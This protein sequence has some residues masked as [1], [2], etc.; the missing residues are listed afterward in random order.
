MFFSIVITTYN[1]EPYILDAL[2]S[3]K[4]QTFQD[5]E[6]IITD[7]FSTDNTL[8]VCKA[9]VAKHP[10]FQSRLKIIESKI[11]TGISA[12]TN[13]GLKV[14]SGKWIHVLSG[15]DALVESALEKTYDFV[16]AHPEFSIFQGI[17]A[18]YNN[19]FSESNFIGHLSENYKT[20]D[21]FNRSVNRQYQ[22]LLD[23]C[24]VVA[25][26]VFYKKDSVESVGFCDEN[27]PMIDDWPLYLKF[28]KHGYK[29]HFWNQILVKY[30][31]HKTS[32][33][34]ENKGFLL[35]DIH[36]KCRPVYR[37]YIA[38]NI[39]FFKKIKYHSTYIFKDVLY[40]FFNSKNNPIALSMLFVWRLFKKPSLAKKIET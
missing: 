37:N 6:W 29:I 36:R 16:N 8:D 25:P 23:W 18:L 40:R 34:N 11:N 14:A 13:R 22:M 2:N 4:N 9:W 30:R 21:F 20:S 3:L 28:T 38:P 35:T 10:Q 32:I 26:A 39:G 31:Q 15:D 7:D 12:N 19:D 33:A 17:A 27:I 24:H 5:F 1:A